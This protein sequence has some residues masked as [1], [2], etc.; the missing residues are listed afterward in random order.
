MDHNSAAVTASTLPD[1]RIVRTRAALRAALLALLEEKPFDD[2]TIRDL[3]ARAG[4]GYATFFRH[5]SSKAALLDDVV[6]DEIRELLDLS[7]PDVRAT[8]TRAA[9]MAMCRHVDERRAL[10]SVLLTGGAAGRM[11]EEFIRQAAANVP[12]VVSNNSWLPDD[13]KVLFGVAGAVEILAWWLYRGREC[14]IE[15]AAEIVDR[16]VVA[17]MVRAP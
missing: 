3:S 8:D 17:P 13:L 14:T 16:L 4:I 15:R 2:I 7:I 6:A 10:W 11:R 1:A 12:D 9:A 5:Y